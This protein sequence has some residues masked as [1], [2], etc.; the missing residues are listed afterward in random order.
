[1]GIIRTTGRCNAP[2]AR[3]SH[4]GWEIGAIIVIGDLRSAGAHGQETGAIKEFQDR[5]LPGMRQVV[6]GPQRAGFKRRG[7]QSLSAGGGEFEGDDAVDGG[8]RCGDSGLADGIKFNC[9]GTY[10]F[11]Y[12]FEITSR[13]PETIPS[14]IF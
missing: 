11:I 6:E 7:Y 3:A 1:M 5:R 2:R 10:N 14:I 8:D 13:T 4:P 9:S 12:G